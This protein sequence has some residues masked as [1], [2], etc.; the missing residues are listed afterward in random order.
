M[1][2]RF[3]TWQAYCRCLITLLA[4]CHPTQPFYLHEDGDLSH[5]LDHATEI[6]APDD[7]QSV[8][9][10]DASQS[11]RPLSV[12]NPEFQEFWDIT[13]EEA[14][15]MHLHNSKVIR[16][17]GGLPSPIN[18]TGS[19]I[20]DRLV[21]SPGTQQTIYDPSIVETNP[22]AGV[23]AA[24]SAFDAQ[25]EIDGVTAPG[26]NRFFE[27]TNRP[28]NFSAGAA[29]FFSNQQTLGGLE[30]SITKRSPTGTTYAFRNV[31]N[32]DRDQTGTASRIYQS[33]WTTSF[34][35]EISHPL[36]RGSGTMVNR[37]P[38]LLGRINTDV[39][40][41][42]FEAGVRDSIFDVE[43]AYWD[44]YGAYRNLEAQKV[45]RNSALRT[46]KV[47]NAKR[48]GET[49]TAQSE[50]QAREQYYLFKSRVE[51][52]ITE[53]YNTEANMRFL[54]GIAATDG[55]LL[56]PADEPVAAKLELNWFDIH[57]EALARTIELRRQKWLI[58]QRELQLISARNQLLP[59]L[60][61]VGTY[62]WVGR[63]DE[64]GLGE[65]NGADFGTAGATAFDVLTDGAFQEYS[66][67]FLFRPP[68][69]GARAELNNIRNAELN[70][71]R[72]RARL[73]D[74]EL[75]VSH[76]LSRAYREMELQYATAETQMN[77]L[78]ATIE[79]VEPRR[80]VYEGGARSPQGGEPINL[81]LDA[82][83]RRADA[84]QAYYQA[85]VGYMKQIAHV[86]YR[87]GSYL[88]Y[89]NI[90]LAEGPWPDKAYW[91]A[92]GHARRRD[93]SYYLDYGWT[94]PSVV[95][96]GPTAQ[97]EGAAMPTSPIPGSSGFGFSEGESMADPDMPGESVLQGGASG[98]EAE[99]V[100]APPP[101]ANQPSFELP[102][103]TPP[104][105]SEPPRLQ[106]G[107]AQASPMSAKRIASL[108]PLR[109]TAAGGDRLRSA[110][111]GDAEVQQASYQESAR[112][113]N[114]SALPSEPSAKR[115]AG[116][117]AWR[118]AQP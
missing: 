87:K 99:S 74:M 112:P 63:G 41:A 33:L 20:P 51:Q 11:H 106:S 8:L 86:H 7:I 96:R 92:L 42:D 1:I 118:T 111:P 90:Q 58:K 70:L 5:Y 98:G 117:A 113:S 59:Q 71:Q 4:G 6:D 17:L 84:E 2:R 26:G 115:P 62:R 72:E 3:R 35:S 85:L 22:N 27:V 61:L 25:F 10:P 97:H 14:M 83:R 39:S 32:Y 64:L 105:G 23:H 89:N 46:W 76:L 49:E 108:S 102:E 55:R 48:E 31:T 56:R 47:V 100:P 60:D 30:T 69:I 73:E 107:A 81:L 45:G 103:A 82:Q 44:L 13:L 54:L 91:D 18:V 80:A 79:E 101:A 110:T 21:T 53:L 65:R 114:I 12:L 50:A 38:V 95:S 67:G 40:L 52:A 43:K 16:G 34:E 36:L 9:L 94:R 68:A 93:A 78:R 29:G 104:Q 28:N 88:E 75:N 15:S 77:R 37:I 57:A 109:S 24:L 19:L 116:Q 66:L